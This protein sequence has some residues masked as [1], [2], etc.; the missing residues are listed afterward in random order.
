L[1][2]NPPVQAAHAGREG[3]DMGK[4]VEVVLTGIRREDFNGDDGPLKVSGGLW[5]VTYDV[6]SAPVNRVEIFTFPDGP[7]R[8]AHNEVVQIGTDARFE[9]TTGEAHEHYPQFIKF[10]G[11]LRIEGS[12]PQ[13]QFEILP[14][15]YVSNENP[16]KY[17]VRFGSSD[18]EF[19][20]DFTVRFVHFL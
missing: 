1:E 6:E 19:R 15:I 9:M 5:G 3:I 17:R 12:F 16:R 13:Q 11:E 20:C 10:G 2:T 18:T 8:F 7:V 4:V 14:S